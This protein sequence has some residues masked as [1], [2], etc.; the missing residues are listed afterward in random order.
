[1]RKNLQKLLA[2]LLMICLMAPS[3]MAAESTASVIDTNLLGS[4][5][6]VKYENQHNEADDVDP[7]IGVEKGKE[8]TAGD[9]HIPIPDVTYTIYRIAD[10]TQGH[11]DGSG[12]SVSVE[13]TSL[14]KSVSGH[15][16]EIPSG[17]TNAEELNT[18]VNGLRDSADT[19]KRIG[20]LDELDYRTGKTDENGVLKFEN[21]P[22][23]IWVCYEA[24]YPI[25]IIEPVCFVVSIPTTA[26][27]DGNDDANQPDDDVLGDNMAGA[28][29]NV[30]MYWDY[31][32]IAR[33]KNVVKD[34][35]VEK[36]IVVD[37]GAAAASESQATGINDPTNDVLSDAEDY[38]MGDTI[39]YSAQAEIPSTIGEIEFYY[40]VER[41]SQ[42]QTFTNDTGS[43]NVVADVE[44]WGEPV[45]G[46]DPVYIPRLTGSTVNWMVTNPGEITKYDDIAEDS[47]AEFAIYLNTQT[48]SEQATNANL[49]S[50][51]RVPLYSKI[52]VTYNVVLN[53]KAI[54]GNPGNPSDIRLEH[55]HVTVDNSLDIAN[56]PNIPTSTDKIDVVNPQCS[57]VKVYTYALD[58]TKTGEGIDEMKGVEFDLCNSRGEKIHLS[59]DDQGYYVDKDAVAPVTIVIDE[60]NMASIR[61]LESAAY[62]LVE[63]KTIEGYN[64]L[65]QPVVLTIASDAADANLAMQYKEDV[66]GE[67]F[68]I[69]EG[70]GYFIEQNGMKLEINIENHAVG[71]YVAVKGEVKSYDLQN[72]N[73]YMESDV[74]TVV[75]RYSYRWTDDEELVWSVNYPVDNGTI[76]ITVYN[77]KGFE[78]PST[79]GVG[80]MPFV[81]VGLMIVIAGVVGA[82]CLNKRKNAL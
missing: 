77:R 23:G 65:R 24:S 72:D 18:F 14:I 20:N 61:G 29:S 47:C 42:G 13:F 36:H 51:K 62:Q 5:T 43:G 4:L 69:E 56:Q 33:P 58:I 64:L 52:W 30:G 35:S 1:M 40:L 9:V 82:C 66:N 12:K 25:T 70:R 73:G 27:N 59:K 48:L 63:T 49:D 11:L 26:V 54:V 76:D 31:D 71:S 81:G 8:G 50:I 67:Y 46:G 28:V 15:T 57:D 78:I 74:K 3:V 45:D 41:L 21:L 19:T 79:G 2:V 10:I 68:R 38:E 39:R 60:D 37:E 32:I 80:V 22:L 44:V 34:L 75:D 6:I 16:I 53:E 17:L 7:G 55:S